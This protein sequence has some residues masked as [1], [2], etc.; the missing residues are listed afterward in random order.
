[1]EKHL[2]MKWTTKI[3]RWDSSSIPGSRLEFRSYPCFLMSTNWYLY[4]VSDYFGGKLKS[5][6]F[7]NKYWTTVQL[8]RENDGKK[9]KVNGICYIESKNR[10]FNKHY[11]HHIIDSEVKHI[12]ISNYNEACLPENDITICCEAWITELTEKEGRSVQTLPTFFKLSGDM[13]VMY[14]KQDHSDLIAICQDK[15]IRVH[16]CIL[17][18]R[19]PVFAKMFQHA[20]SENSDNR[21]VITDIEPDVFEELLQFLYCGKINPSTYS[22]AHDLYYAAEKYF[23]SDLKDLCRDFI[24]SSLSVTSAVETLILAD[25]HKDEEMMEK[26]VSFIAASFQCIKSTEPWIILLQENPTLATQVLSSVEEISDSKKPDEVEITCGLR[27]LKLRVWSVFYPMRK[28]WADCMVGA[29]VKVVKENSST[30]IRPVFNASSHS[31]G[32]P[33][34]N[35]CLSTGPNLIEIIPSILNRFRKYYVGVTS[36]KEKAFLQISIRENDRDFLRFM[37]FSRDNQEQV[38]LYRHRRVVFG[39]T[40]SPFWKSNIRSVVPEEDSSTEGDVSVLGFVWHTV[41]DTLSFKISQDIKLDDPVTKRLVLAVAH[42]VFDV[43]GH[44]APVMLIP[45]LILQE[46]WNLRLKWDDILP[47]E[48]TKKFRFWF[49]KLYLLSSIQIPRWIGLRSINEAVSIHLFCD[50]SKSAYGACVFLRVQSGKKVKKNFCMKL[51][52]RVPDIDNVDKEKLSRR[53]KYLQRMREL[54]RICCEAWI[55]ELTE[56]EEKSVQTLPTFCKL[57]R[58]IHAMYQ[59]QDHFDLIVICKDVEIP[60]HKCIL[61]ARSP[62]FAKMFQH[63]TSENSDNRIVITDI[64][65]DVFEE[66]LQFLY[67]GKINPSTYSKAHDLYYAAEKYFVSDLKDLCRDFITSSLSVTSA[68][69]TLILA[70]RHKDEEMMEKAVSF[71]AASFQCIKSTEPWIILL[72]ENPTLATQVLSSVEEMSHSEKPDEVSRISCSIMNPCSLAICH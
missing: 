33:S 58:D 34:L 27:P 57:S 59:K 48:L 21:I 29:V 16:K 11:L 46:T 3:H 28:G 10:I 25:R 13:Y 70:D 69:E 37:W 17:S 45:K 52:S 8:R 20:T 51:H 35:D 55:R 22:K 38:E 15:E 50:S 40:C 64:E 44:T 4:Y 63:A 60:A 62:V 72:Q 23:V 71:I 49:K 18:A 9:L 6:N 54:L 56:A 65:P 39:I 14:Q 5:Q 66:L 36:D 12:R 32:Y 68:V 53:A 1:M 26:A 24:T 7:G 31:P 43:I 41:T 67:C 30:S 2:S 19:S 47:D 42:Q 61:S